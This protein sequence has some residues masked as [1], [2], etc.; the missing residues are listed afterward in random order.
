MQ[1]ELNEDS[2]RS[3]L[4]QSSQENTEDSQHGFH[5][6]NEHLSRQLHA[7]EGKAKPRRSASGTTLSASSAGSSDDGREGPL[8][9]LSPPSTQKSGSPVDR[10]IK[11]EKDSTYLPK[12]RVEGRAF[13]VVQSGSSLGSAQTA[14]GDFPNGLHSTLASLRRWLISLQ[15]S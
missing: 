9:R 15:R 14:I 2:Q 12:K 10:I 6:S 1:P 7:G 8:R 11:H 5:D 3:L 4:P 13:T